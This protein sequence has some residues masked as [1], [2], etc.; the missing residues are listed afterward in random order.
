[1]TWRSLLKLIGTVVLLSTTAVGA[2]RWGAPAQISIGDR[3]LGPELA[4]NLSGEGLVVWD[5]EVGSEC[6]TAPAALSCIH[7]VEA[8]GRARGAALW[9]APVEVA[10]PGVGSRPRV[11][12]DQSGNAAIVWVHDIGR[13]RVLQATYR[14]GSS[15]SWP[16]PNDI[17]E[18]SLRVVGHQVALDAL[19]DAVTV[20]AEL[21]GCC[22][23]LR[24]AVRTTTSGGWGAAARFSGPFVTSNPALAVTPTGSAVAAWVGGGRSVLVSHGDAVA[25]TWEPPIYLPTA[26]EPKRD[27]RVAMN[28]AGD[29]AVAWVDWSS[30]EVQA[31]FRSRSGDWGSPVSLGSARPTSGAP[32]VVVDDTGN[33]L[34]AWLSPTGVSTSARSITTG[35]WSPP[36][37]VSTLQ[38]ASDLQLAMGTSGN[39]V[40]VWASGENGSVQAAIRPGASGAWQPPIGFSAAG[41][42][43][44]GVAMDGSGNAVAVWN[45]SSGQQIVVESADLDGSG[46]VLENVRIPKRATVRTRVTFSVTPVPWASPLVGTPRWRFGDGGSATGN[47]ATH[48]YSRPGRYDV[49]VSQADVAG[50]TSTSTAVVKVIGAR[51]RNAQ[52]PS[53]KGVPRVGR[54]LR[55]LRGRWIGSSPIRYAFS[56]TRDGKIISGAT[57]T[58][59]RLTRHDRGSLIACAVEATNPMGSS[60]AASEPVEIER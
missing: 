8:A 59:Y 24:A 44:P 45:R 48:M 5:Q 1:M 38:T 58:R 46:P 2:P 42:Y 21:E 35:L 22:F 3:A 17:S 4:L 56:W 27:P 47:R 60:R 6:P 19:G 7:I 25:G 36:G 9:Q 55:C 16:E 34:A 53:I 52:P 32:Q 26:N 29:M 40:A 18:P 10:R 13:D 41:A 20:W 12:I 28:A 33:T 54:T 14:R 49:S 30:D 37:T 11:A 50:G 39:A 57:R 31:V 23:T 43:K 51:V 15:G